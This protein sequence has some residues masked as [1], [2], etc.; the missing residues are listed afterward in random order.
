MIGRPIA[1]SKRR[2]RALARR[3]DTLL[4]TASLPCGHPGTTKKPSGQP[5]RAARISAVGRS[6]NAGSRAGQALDLLRASRLPSPSG[7]SKASFRWRHSGPAGAALPPQTFSAASRMD[8]GMVGSSGASATAADRIW[9]IM[10]F[11]VE[12][13]GHPCS[14]TRSTPSW[15]FAQKNSRPSFKPLRG[16]HLRAIAALCTSGV[17]CDEV[18]SYARRL[19]VDVAA[20]VTGGA[21]FEC[22]LPPRKVQMRA[23]MISR[24]AASQSETRSRKGELESE[25]A[26]RLRSP[27]SN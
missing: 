17:D 20:A 13:N 26:H 27:G 7:A 22:L 18:G 23:R 15:L 9:D 14:A 16:P 3:N 21:V 24:L 19:V 5:S 8:G 12:E 6:I 1:G 25:F 11:Q 4:V 10:Q 2:R